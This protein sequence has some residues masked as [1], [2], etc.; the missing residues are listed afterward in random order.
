MAGVVPRAHQ[1]EEA[2]RHTETTAFTS[3]P[4]D[5]FVITTLKSRPCADCGQTFP[6]Q[7]MDFDHLENKAEI[8]SKLVYTVSTRTLLLEV[9][10]CEVVCANC[11]RIRTSMRQTMPDFD[12]T[13]L[14]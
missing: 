11:H 8:V 7:A 13:S 14:N 1:Q 10:K 6:T 12:S 2:S 5:Q 4:H 9:A 3:H